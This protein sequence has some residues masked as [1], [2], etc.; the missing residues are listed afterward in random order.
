MQCT[1]V[2]F[3]L[4]GYNFVIHWGTRRANAPHGGVLPVLSAGKAICFEV[5]IYHQQNHTYICISHFL[6]YITNKTT[7]TYTHKY[8]TNKTTHIYMYHTFCSLPLKVETDIYM[9]VVLLVKTI[10]C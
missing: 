1:A 5:Y 10:L 3:D 9:C 4:H 6:H 2:Q 8:M 7:L